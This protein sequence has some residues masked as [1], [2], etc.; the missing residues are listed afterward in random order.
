VA[1]TRR[2]DVV[3]FGALNLDVMY[4]VESVE[5]AGLEP[6]SEVVGAPD[7]HRAL[8]H[9]LARGGPP[10][11][12]SA[13]GSAGNTVFALAR[14]G[15][16]TGFVGAVGEEP[17]SALL[18]EGLGAREDL[19]VARRGTSG[20]AVMAVDADGERSTAVFPNANDT[21]SEGDV[22]HAL[23]AGARAVHMT[24]F[25]GDAP[26]RAQSEAA[27]RLPEGVLLTF[28]PGAMYS[29][30]GLVAVAHILERAD[31]VLATED[32][33]LEL[34]D[35]TDRDRAARRVQA[36]G[37]GVVACKLGGRGMHVYWEGRD[38]LHRAHPVKVAS[39]AIGVGDVAAAGF[40]AGM[41]EGLRPDQCAAVAHVCAVESLG[42]GGRASYPDRRV[43]WRLVEA[44]LAAQGG[45]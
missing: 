31:L 14:M 26:L 23:L 16:R 22:D 6:G 27:R 11:A 43:L 1:Q 36:A 9:R 33:L 15:Y 38:Q 30:R 19:R 17:E 29:H 13:G 28:D 32:E 10:A 45:E 42:G 3:G 5:D 40:I 20:R 4:R 39:D 25:A 8:E 2:L 7:G 34:A 12:V 41:L 18:L 35:E 24:S 37:V 21:L 44:Q